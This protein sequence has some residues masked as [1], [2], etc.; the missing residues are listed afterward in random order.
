MEIYKINKYKNIICTLRWHL[1][2]TKVVPIN[3]FLQILHF[4]KASY[5]D[6]NIY[7]FSNR[8]TLGMTH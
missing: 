5:Y 8:S 6:R 7:H 4:F 1:L 2:E 3:K